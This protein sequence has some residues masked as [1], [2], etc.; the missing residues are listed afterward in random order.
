MSAHASS[1]RSSPI[2]NVEFVVPSDAPAW[3][4]DLAMG[5]VEARRVI[6]PYRRC[7]IGPTRL[8]RKGKYA[9]A[10]E[11]RKPGAPFIT[12]D[13]NGRARG[14]FGSWAGAATDLVRIAQEYERGRL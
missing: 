7:T 5:E 10:V 3:C 11:V 13:A 14:I 4:A 8:T 2:R 12:Y 1:R 6:E 9:A